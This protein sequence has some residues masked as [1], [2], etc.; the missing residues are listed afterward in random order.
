[1]LGAEPT[2]VQDFVEDDEA[3]DEGEGDGGFFGF[4]AGWGEGYA[5]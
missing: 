4:G 2:E 1:V 3:L 5:W